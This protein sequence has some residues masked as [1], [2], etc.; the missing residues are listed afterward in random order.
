MFYRIALHRPYFLRRLDGDRFDRSRHACIESSKHDSEIRQNFYK[1]A[2]RQ[3]IDASGGMYRAFQSTMICGI[4][5]I[6]DSNR[7]DAQEMHAILDN[8]LR[9]TRETASHD[10]DVA[11]QRELKIIKFLR[12]KVAKD[13]GKAPP[14][15][16]VA[17]TEETALPRSGCNPQPFGFPQSPTRQPTI[18]SSADK[19]VQ[20]TS[21]RLSLYSSPTST[22]PAAFSSNVASQP[23]IPSYPGGDNWTRLDGG[24]SGSTTWSYDDTGFADNQTF[25]ANEQ[26]AG[27]SD[28]VPDIME[29][30]FNGDNDL[31]EGTGEWSYWEALLS[32]LR[33]SGVS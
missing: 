5:L 16:N 8:F 2:S 29:T 21:H 17:E 6:I 4:A 13:P 24:Q 7:D 11:T 9:A 33:V 3:V 15:P 22:D 10:M 20:H 32:Q 14:L 25:Q 12:S 31:S 23:S 27:G 18:R 26:W 28:I 30:M 1:N 19:Q